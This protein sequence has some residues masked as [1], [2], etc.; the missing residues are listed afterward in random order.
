MPAGAFCYIEQEDF[1]DENTMTLAPLCEAAVPEPHCP[2]T[3]STPHSRESLGAAVFVDTLGNGVPGIPTLAG[4]F[5]E[6][7]YGP[8]PFFINVSLSLIS[9]DFE[10]I[11]E[12]YEPRWRSALKTASGLF[13]SVVCVLPAVLALSS[14]LS[15]CSTNHGSVRSS[16]QSRAA[17]HLEHDFSQGLDGWYGGRDWAKNWIR[18]PGTGYIRA[19]Q[20]AL[21]RPSQQMTDYVM[22]FL[23][24]ID[25][26]S[27]AWVYRAADLQNYYVSKLI[28]VKPGPQPSM[29]LVRY[30]VIGG[31]ETQHLQVPVRMILHNKRPYRIRQEA[32]GDGFTTSIE[33]EVVDFFTDDRL[34][35]G[36]VGFLGEQGGAPHLY[37]VKVTYQDDFWGKLCAT[38]APNN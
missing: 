7:P 16:I 33:G 13:R 28:V 9:L 22:E 11:L 18:E 2:G 20:L 15:G 5:G 17:V 32:N 24:Q 21:Y 1:D 19:G 36:G 14:M 29:A 23:G 10:T 34:R 27:L 6:Q 3:S 30:Q 12:T 25:G 26:S 31:Q 37:W 38:I 8:E 35:A 4:G